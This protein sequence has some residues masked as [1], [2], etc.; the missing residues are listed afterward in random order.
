M[1]PHLTWATA[2]K[3]SKSRL[4]ERRGAEM[5]QVGEGVKGARRQG[6]QKAKTPDKR[7][8]KYTSKFGKEYLLDVDYVDDGKQPLNA[9]LSHSWNST[10]TTTTT[11]T[12]TTSTKMKKMKAPKPK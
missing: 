2:S 11:S 10:P 5:S 3:P 6:Q 1:T 7:P 12:T 9:F 4:P 8:A